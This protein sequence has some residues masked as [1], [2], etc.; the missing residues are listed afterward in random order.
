MSMRCIDA[1]DIAILAAGTIFCAAV[2]GI[3]D[4]HKN[5]P[6]LSVLWVQ[7]GEGRFRTFYIEKNFTFF[8]PCVKY[9]F[10]FH[11]PAPPSFRALSPYGAWMK[12]VPVGAGRLQTFL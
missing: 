6:L 2:P 7:V 5:P 10:D 1:I 11:R 3:P 4:G 8:L 12:K 9:V